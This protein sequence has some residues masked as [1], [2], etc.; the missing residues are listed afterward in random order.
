MCWSSFVIKSLIEC[1]E[2]STERTGRRH[3]R[4]VYKAELVKS[5]LQGE[6]NR[7]KL[8]P[9]PPMS[10]SAGLTGC[11]ESPMRDEKEKNPWFPFLGNKGQRSWRS[12]LRH[13]CP[14]RSNVATESYQFWRVIAVSFFLSC[15]R[16]RERQTYPPPTLQTPAFTEQEVRESR[17]RQ[18]SNKMD[19][20]QKNL[21]FR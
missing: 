19:L 6:W 8:S 20:A 3:Q 18:M 12:W 9:I 10:S 11:G 15:V 7:E 13:C 2:P 17:R 14:C 16:T 5:F 21:D 1:Q 4:D